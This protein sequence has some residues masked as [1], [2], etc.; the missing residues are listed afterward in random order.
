MNSWLFPVTATV[1]ERLSRT[2]NAAMVGAE[3]DSVACM[4]QEHLEASPICSLPFF[5]ISSTVAVK[6][7]SSGIAF[8]RAIHWL[9]VKESCL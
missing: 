4:M 2:E 1:E 8:S 9:T 5:V 3:L 6:D 7:F